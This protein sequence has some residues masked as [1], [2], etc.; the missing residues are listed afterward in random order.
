[1]QILITIVH[2]VACIVLIL[3][4]LLQAGKGAN[5]G[6]VFGGSSQTIFGSS[7]PGTFLGKM[8]TAVAVIFMLTSLSLSYS[9][10]H[11]GS[12]LMEG[13]EKPV[14]QPTAPAPLATQ[15]VPVQIPQQTGPGQTPKQTVPVQ[16]PQKRVPVPSPAAPQTAK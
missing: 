5:I 8:T 6:A 10:S 13:A 16:I 11:R 7:G 3:V 9:V 15:T 14:A 1:M 12:S 4:V 2:I